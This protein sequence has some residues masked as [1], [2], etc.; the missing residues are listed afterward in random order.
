M[1][2]P[3]YSTESGRL[4]HAGRI[5]ICSVGLPARGKTH[6]SHAT[7][8]YLKWLGVRTEVFSLGDARRRILGPPTALPSDYFAPLGT[9]R[10]PETE[11]LRA[12]V[13]KGLEEDMDK[14]FFQENGQ[15]AIYD[16]NNGTIKQR[17]D[18]R[19]LWG[20]KGVH[21]MFIESICDKQEVIEANIRRV[22]ISS[23][24]YKGWDPEKAVADYWKRIQRHAELYEPIENPTFP[25]VK[26]VNVGE[27]IIVNNIQGYLQSRIVFFLMNIHIKHRTIWF[28]R[29]GPSLIEH[30]Y[31][32]DSDL[33]PEGYAYADKLKD[34]V[35]K[36]R[37]EIRDERMRNGERSNM[38]HMTVW[39]SARQRC[40]STA[41][42]FR[43]LGYRV[44]ERAQMSEINPGVIDGYTVEE[45]KES[46]PEEYE[47][48]LREPYSHRYPRAESYHDLSVR[49]EPVIFELERERSDMLVIG[50][51]SVLRCLFAYLTG[52]PPA[53]I[54]S[55]DIR[56]G[57]LVEIRPASYGVSYSVHEFWRP[58]PQDLSDD[59]P[60]N[61]DAFIKNPG[62][63][64][65]EH[66]KHKASDHFLDPDDGDPHSH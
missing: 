20:P 19:A 35:I 15:V 16:A 26:I 25:Y 63:G 39:T 45:I 60:E 56:R 59:F 48:S 57:D 3:L 55:V 62:P 43:D 32:A 6:V 64:H 29:S 38:K 41:K 17:N 2:A 46:Y 51:A 28:A 1:A 4:W 14:F 58:R 53:Q 49:L 9:Q 24:D 23:P 22:K 13:R 52:L 5:L 50:H 54:P 33:D 31:K 18:L 8:R 65:N 12:K 30:S 42:P 27:R 10:S 36:K 61:E 47:R 40:L 7:E 34:F 21:V 66:L 11:N 44:I 37:K